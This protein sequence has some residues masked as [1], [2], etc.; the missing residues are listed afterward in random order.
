M[1]PGCGKEPALLWIGKVAEDALGQACC[2][3]QIPFFSSGFIQVYET[4]G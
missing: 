1:V 2:L 4:F 3:V